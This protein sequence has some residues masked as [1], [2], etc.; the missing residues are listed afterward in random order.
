MTIHR[1]YSEQK[2][3][4]TCFAF[5]DFSFVTGSL[6]AL[7]EA[8]GSLG[9]RGNSSLGSVLIRQLTELQLITS[10]RSVESAGISVN[11]AGWH[12]SPMSQCSWLRCIQLRD[13]TRKLR[14]PS[15]WWSCHGNST[16]VVVWT[17]NHLGQL[18][19]NTWVFPALNQ[20]IQLNIDIKLTEMMIYSG[21]SYF[22]WECVH[23]LICSL[24][25]SKKIPTV[26]KFIRLISKN[27]TSAH[28]LILARYDPE[29]AKKCVLKY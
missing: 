1:P 3:W 29:L 9:C 25:L 15:V 21:M 19:L 26:T 20:P 17:E 7:S 24:D 18:H 10:S 22:F 14:Y 13:T 6:P 23:D 5:L 28:T 16:Y 27:F 8:I 4:E 2:E 11:S 12:W